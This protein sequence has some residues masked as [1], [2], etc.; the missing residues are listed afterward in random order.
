MLYSWLNSDGFSI[1]V[2][3][4]LSTSETVPPEAM[5]QAV[6]FMRVLRLTRLSMP[7]GRP[8]AFMV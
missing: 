5:V 1:T 3:V 4:L 8:Y 2:N 6:I 7:D